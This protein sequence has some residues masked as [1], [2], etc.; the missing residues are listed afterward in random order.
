MIPF[1]VYDAKFMEEQPSEKHTIKQAFRIGLLDGS[2]VKD[3][4]NAAT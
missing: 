4:A 1:L 3:I 2:H